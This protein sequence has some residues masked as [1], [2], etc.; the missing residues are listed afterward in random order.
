[1]TRSV[2]LCCLL[3]GNLG[4]RCQRTAG[5]ERQQGWLEKKQPRFQHPS[6]RLPPRPL[7]RLPLCLPL[8]FQYKTAASTFQVLP[9][10]GKQRHFENSVEGKVGNLFRWIWGCRR[11]ALC[12]G[13]WGLGTG[14][15]G[16]SVCHRTSLY[17]ELDMVLRLP[18]LQATLCF[19]SPTSKCP[20]AYSP[21]WPR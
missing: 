14:R 21:L 18:V 8:C 9:R 16:V 3:L 15:L 5:S 4:F 6:P 2:Q 1:M 10:R 20:G 13:H 19:S 12:A 11:K 17:E 7:P